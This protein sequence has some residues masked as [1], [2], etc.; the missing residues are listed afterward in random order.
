MT[1]TTRRRARAPV[2]S[3]GFT[4]PFS[5]FSVELADFAGTVAFSIDTL[6]APGGWRLLVQLSPISPWA[7]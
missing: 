3:A 6:T 7:R 4:S 2:S 1:T 5:G